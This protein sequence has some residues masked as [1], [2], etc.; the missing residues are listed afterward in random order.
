MKLGI[1]HAY[2]A[3]IEVAS[4]LREIRPDLPVVLASGYITEKLRTQAP[5]A[6]IRE[7]IYK[8]NTVDDLCEAAA[9]LAQKPQHLKPNQAPTRLQARN[10]G[11]GQR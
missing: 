4:T 7:L 9:R 1:A 11:S 3:S 5:A 10:S 2:E 6:G 8:P